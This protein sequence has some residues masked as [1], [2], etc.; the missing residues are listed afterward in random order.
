MRSKQEQGFTVVELLVVISIIGMLMALLLPAVQ[1]AREAGRR[2]TCA[3]NLKNCTLAILYYESAKGQY[4]GWRE[5]MEV[6]IPGSSSSRQIPVSWVVVVLPYLERTDVYNLWCDP[7]Q[8]AAAGIEWPPQLY[9]GTLNCPSS[10]PP[11]SAKSACV[12]VVN[13]GMSDWYPFSPGATSAPFPADF[14]ANGMFFNHFY[15]V[16]GAN[17]APFVSY[18]C[19]E[20]IVHT[21]Q[22]YVTT[23]DGSTHT[24]MVSENNDVPAFAPVGVAPSGLNGGPSSWGDPGTAAY[25]KQNCFVFWPEKHPDP[26]MKVNSR[27][28]APSSSIYYN[29]FLRPASSHPGGVNASFCDGHVRYLSDTIDYGAYSLV[30]TPHGALCNTPSTVGGLDGAG[31]TPTY[32][33]SEWYSTNNYAY[34]RTALIDDSMLP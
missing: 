3:N 31:G 26:A 33:T 34:L 28:L 17:V 4:P 8:A 2:N 23:N 16:N 18:P 6:A 5:P 20:P 9:L 12:Y 21:S 1:Q 11:S 10:P 29:F 7:E 25:E 13:S 14:Q 32:L 24:L 15:Q 22:N 19:I 27:P 30:M